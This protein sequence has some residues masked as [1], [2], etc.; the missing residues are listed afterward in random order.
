MAACAKSQ[1][2][3]VE[4]FIALGGG[5]VQEGIEARTG[6][7]MGNPA[8]PRLILLTGEK[9]PGKVRQLGLLVRRERFADSQRLKT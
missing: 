8:F 5:I 4:W 3:G 1:A 9:K 6:F 2:A 7:G